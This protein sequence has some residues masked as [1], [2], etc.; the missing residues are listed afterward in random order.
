MKRITGW[1]LLMAVLLTLPMS[2]LAI[3]LT[4]SYTF[5]RP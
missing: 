4:R 1:I 2:A 3:D 5:D